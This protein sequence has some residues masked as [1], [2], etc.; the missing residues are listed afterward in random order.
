MPDFLGA[1]PNSCRMGALQGHKLTLQR[2]ANSP[3]IYVVS[4][5][6]VG[7]VIVNGCQLEKVLQ[8]EN[9]TQLLVCH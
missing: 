7:A 9:K 3:G 5:L 1:L 8:S 4:D 6:G 2:Q